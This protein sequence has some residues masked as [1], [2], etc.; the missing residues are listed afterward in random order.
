MAPSSIIGTQS[1]RVNKNSGL[2]LG[3]WLR[4]LRTTCLVD[5]PTGASAKKSVSLQQHEQSRR[6][7]RLVDGWL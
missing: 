7:S 3:E 2:G 1:L 6:A 4:C 5:S